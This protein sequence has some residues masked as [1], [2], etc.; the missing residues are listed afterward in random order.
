MKTT[1]HAILFATIAAAGIAGA[2]L[3]PAADLSR[4][5]PPAPVYVPPPF[6][7]TG[8]YLGG[9]LGGA[10]AQ[11]NVTDTLT[12]L[13]FSSGNSNGVFVGGGQTGFNYQVGSFVLGAEADFDWAANHNGTAS[14]VVVAGPLGLGHAFAA[15]VNNGWITTFTGRLGYAWDRVLLYGKGGG[16]WVSN[17]GLTVTDVTTG[18]S[19]SGSSSNSTSGWT[20]GAGV[21]WAFANNWTVRGE[22]DYIGLGSRSFTVPAVSPVLPGDTFTA[23]RNIQMVTVGLNY[24]F[25]WSSPVAARY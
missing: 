3:A 7:W 20:A 12:G 21:E 25:N 5:P 19:V 2:R 1:R 17:G 23:S 9:N 11:G 10:W 6:T 13:N 4:A 16:A 8:F 14:G 22:Y 18:L 15:G 24:L